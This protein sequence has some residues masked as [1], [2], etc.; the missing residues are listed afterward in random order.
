ML[1]LL[2]RLV[3]PAALAFRAEMVADGA[4]AVHGEWMAVAARAAPK[5]GAAAFGGAGGG[6]GTGKSK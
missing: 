6:D 3:R 4:G 2:L 5:S 1:L